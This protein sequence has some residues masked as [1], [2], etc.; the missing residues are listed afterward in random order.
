MQ[1][2]DSINFVGAM[3]LVPTLWGPGGQ[4]GHESP[5]VAKLKVCMVLDQNSRV[6]KWG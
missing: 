4:G 2:N 5:K 3:W 1:L 6:I